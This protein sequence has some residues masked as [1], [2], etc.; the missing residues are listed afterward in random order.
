M[1]PTS[2]AST[3]LFGCIVIAAIAGAYAWPV[4]HERTAVVDGGPVS[5][6]PAPLAQPRL[7]DQPPLGWPAPSRAPT[8]ALPNRG[9]GDQRPG[10]LGKLLDETPPARPPASV[11]P[12]AQAMPPLLPRSMPPGAQPSELARAVAESAIVTPDVLDVTSAEKITLK[13]Q[14]YANLTGDYRVG[15]D[16]MISVPVLGRISVARKTAAEL[17]RMLAE[18]LGRLTGREAHVTVEINE[19]KPI[20]ATGFLTRPGSF[21]WKPGMT[22]LHAETM[23]GGIFRAI[24]GGATVTGDSERTKVQR[25]VSDL[26]RL[27]AALAR[28]QA[29]RRSAAK[30]DVPAELVALVGPVE[31]EALIAA[32]STL[33]QS[34]RTAHEN[35]LKAIE[36]STSTAQQ[37][38]AGLQKQRVSLQQQ[39]DM[40][41]ASQNRFDGLLA[42]G[43]VSA[44]KAIEVQSKIAD[45]EEKTTNVIVATARVQAALLGFQREALNLRH[46][47]QAQID[48]EIFRIERE[49]A[50]LRIEVDAARSALRRMGG[51]IAG[52]DGT[53]TGSTIA[54][55]IVRQ[56]SG[57]AHTV[58]ASR[59]TPL[60]PGDIVVVS[61]RETR[62]SD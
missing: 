21:P 30:I 31:A 13:F 25:G 55:E 49:A 15:A 9:H 19:Y 16:D 35:Q 61:A 62:R 6:M 39:I 50:Q 41:R 43:L 12:S 5:P 42:K 23:S 52:E 34:R 33:L 17:E 40:R 38:L 24:E 7:P 14:G 28:L 47:R 27:L 36:N 53:E 54:Y 58:A 18:R 20:F 46:E 60:K 51:S 37:E 11:V 44:E 59:F 32:Q 1:K 29:E 22:V 10:D 8:G 45:L 2:P 4:H 26:K 56:E 57:R 3:V 48:T